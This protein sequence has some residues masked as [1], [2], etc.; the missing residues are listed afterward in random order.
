LDVE[1][2]EV[3]FTERAALQLLFALGGVV[4]GL[5]GSQNLA[6]ECLVDFVAVKVLEVQACALQHAR[7]GVARAQKQAVVSHVN[8]VALLKA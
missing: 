2:L 8:R 3:D 4:H 7:D 1:F 6:S 5:E